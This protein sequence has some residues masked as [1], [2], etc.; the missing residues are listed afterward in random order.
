MG[1][2]NIQR[3]RAIQLLGAGTAT[4]LAG[5]AGDEPESETTTEAGTGD[6]LDE[7]NI[8]VPAAFDP[9]DPHQTTFIGMSSVSM[10]AYEGLMGRNNDG[11]IVPKLATDWERLE[12]GRFRFELRE[13]V[14][15]H[16]GNEFTAEDVQYSI[17]RIVDNDVDIQSNRV[18]TLGPVE[19]AEIVDD[20]TVDVISDGLNTAIISSFASYLGLI[21]QNKDWVESND[22][23][24]VITNMN[25]TGPYELVEFDEDEIAIF[26]P[27]DD[28]WG[29]FGEGPDD[30]IDVDRLVFTF[31]GEGS[32]RANQLLAGEAD[33]VESVQ[34][35]DISTIQDG[36]DVR[37]ESAPSSRVMGLFMDTRQ[38]PWS[39][40]EFRQA[41]NYAVDVEGYIENVMN[42]FAVNSTQP[43]LPEM[44]GYD[45]GIDPYGYDPELAE[46]LVEE[47]GMAGAEVELTVGTGRYI[48]GVEI[49]NA[50]A[51]DIDS[52]PNVSCSVEPVDWS[53]FS[54]WYQDTQPEEMD[55][56]FVGYGHP[57]FD[58]TQTIGEFV[59]SRRRS[60]YYEDGHSEIEEL[61]EESLE[62]EDDD[63]R[64]A[65]L[66]EAGQ[67]LVEDAGW[68]FLHQQQSIIGVNELLDWEMRLDEIVTVLE[69]DHAN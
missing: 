2:H 4:A 3:R 65:L 55:F 46:E 8:T 68:V 35:Q 58:A 38:D 52:L 9:A 26:E 53:T 13:G 18:D 40:L 51:N 20:Y 36:P 54:T 56:F 69:A 60:R 41:M 28:Y 61:Y 10:H 32:T 64:E 37:I 17:R 50:I 66:Q 23:E 57:S 22:D 29:S 47:S 6:Q 42:G 1:E 59:L 49:A 34:P 33:L 16:N 62:T 63:E 30:P 44:F 25:G 15:F 43:A 12:P 45:P 39:S 67:I 21:I 7:I 24:H 31:T 5:C 14:T 48:L 19:D 11:E 27:Y